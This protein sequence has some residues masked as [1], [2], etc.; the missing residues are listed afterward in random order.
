VKLFRRRRERARA[1]DFHEVFECDAMQ[2]GVSPSVAFL[3]MLAANI[4]IVANF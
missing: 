1:R 2:H 4:E 3:A